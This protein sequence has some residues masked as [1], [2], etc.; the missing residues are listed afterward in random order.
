MK[1][2]SIKLILIII[3]LLF[4]ILSMFTVMQTEYALK[5]RFG[6]AIDASYEPGLHIKIPFI[7]KIRYFD[8]RIQTLDAPPEHFLTSEKKNLIVDSFV[9]WRI[10][11]VISYYTSVGGNEQR[12]GQRLAAIIA[13]SLRSKFGKHTIQEAVSGNRVAI[14]EEI[15]KEAN[16]R[17]KNFGMEVVDVRV[18]RI[19]LPKEVSSSVYKRMEAERERVAKELRSRGRAEAVRIR[20]SADRHKVELISIAQKDAETTKGQ[21][22]AQAASTYANAYNQD[23]EFY[24]FYRRL[25]AYRDSF[26]NKSD[27]LMLKPDTDFFKYFKDSTAKVK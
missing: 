27:I 4:A 18:K 9:K 26:A 17:I 6:K 14:M 25:G 12:A 13:D 19:E 16:K 21:G 24:A 3:L 23:K 1:L 15:T 11:D 20:A 5:L 8:K 2:T 22:D 7:E 10:I